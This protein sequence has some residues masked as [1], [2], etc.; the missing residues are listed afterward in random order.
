[1]KKIIILVL[2]LI[3]FSFIS[4]NDSINQYAPF[5]VDYVL[6]GIIRGDSTYQIV[7]I[8]RSYQPDGPSPSEYKDDPS[9]TGAKI[10]L[11]YDN[12]V[13]YFRDSSVA[14]VDTTHFNSP[15]RFYYLKNFKPV[16]NKTIV[17]KAYLQN[18]KILQS[19]T[20]TPNVSG[21]SFFD[22][23]S[24]YAF[25][26]DSGGYSYIIWDDLGRNAYAPNLNIN[27][28]IKGDSTLYKIL[29]PLSY[30]NDGSPE[31][32]KILRENY[33]RIDT[34]SV[35]KTLDLLVKK[36]KDKSELTILD[37]TLDLLVLDEYLSAYYSSLLFGL[38]GFTIRIDDPDYT[39]IKG[40]LGIFGSYVRKQFTTTFKDGYLKRL[41]FQ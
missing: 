24:T 1:M 10:E 2:L 40:G 36:Y 8:T 31:Y 41:G 20:K 5:T 11:Y 29:L 26:P 18:G 38:N 23:A 15:F 37:I 16:I 4:C 3:T 14:R 25:P 30:Y 12:Q 35:L 32:A 13:Y 19:E 6:N 39:N 22:R 27:Y 7:T 34:N 33:I 28:K 9:I 21:Y 17:I